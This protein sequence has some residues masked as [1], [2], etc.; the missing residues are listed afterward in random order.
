MVKE[1]NGALVV[2]KF[3]IVKEGSLGKFA[4]LFWCISNG[5][6]KAATEVAAFQKINA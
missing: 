4:M 5:I 3:W 2:G 6:K 1:M